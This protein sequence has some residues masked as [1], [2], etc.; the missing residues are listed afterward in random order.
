MVDLTPELKIAL[1]AAI[2][3][4]R[5]RRHEFATTE[6]LMLALLEDSVTARAV[7]RCGGNVRRLKD[8]L[9]HFLD[10]H[11]ET[12]PDSYPVDVMPT[13]GFQEAVRRAVLNAQT[14]E[15]DVV[16]GPHVV[17]A[18]FNLRDCHAVYLLQQEGI[19]KL[20]LMEY[21]SHGGLDDE[22]YDLDDDEDEDDDDD[23]SVDAE[24]RG[25]DDGEPQSPKKALEKYAVNLNEEAAQGRID[26]MVGRARELARTIHVLCRRRKNNP[27]F[28][29]EAGVG[30]T[31]IVEGLAL[32]IHD[33]T[34]PRP[35]QDAVVYAL[36]VGALVAGTRYRGDFE[37]RLKAVV[38]RLEKLPH[39]ILFVDEIHTLI[40][41]GAAS[42]GA[43]DASSILKPLLARGKLRCI[44][45]TTWKEYRGIFERDQALSRRFQRITVDEPSVE[46]TIE[47][48]RGLKPRYEEFHGITFADDA[49]E[50]AAR[51]SARFLNDRF[52]PD[53]AIDVI[54][55][56]AAEVKLAER[57]RVE[58]ADIDNTLAR[59]ANVP[60]KQVSRD[61][62]S[63]L[64]E[65]E[66]EL[67]AAIYGQDEAIAQLATAIKLSRSGLGE[68]D[69]PIG[70]FLF[71]GPTGVGKTEVCRQLARVLGLEL[72]RY[73]MSEYME[74]HTVSRLI[75][76]PP[77]YVGFDQGGQLTD[78]VTKNPHSVVL[79]DEIEKAHPDV[80]NLL[81]QVMDHGTLTDNNGKKT[82]FRNV[83]LVMTSN[84]GARD[85]Q[86]ARPGF[87]AAGA[88]RAGD[89]DEAYKRRF[90]PEFRNRLDARIKFA[91]LPPEI[92][93][94][95]AD[96]FVRQLQAQLADRKV[97][98]EVTDTAR[99]VLARIGY[100]PQNGARPMARIIREKIKRPLADDLLF[101]RL[102]DG[103]KLVVDAESKDA[104]VFVF[105]FPEAPAGEQVLTPAAESEPAA[106]SK[107]AAESKPAAPDATVNSGAPAPSPAP[108]D[109]D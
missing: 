35:L 54:D 68:P 8:A 27:V 42:G 86:R 97:E 80:F 53:K 90:S 21:V 33:K 72:L 91:P 3:T 75:G 60:P 69:K 26:P 19:N 20:D 76:A 55:E 12:L 46:E 13:L 81:L 71:S 51:A 66:G 41:A 47:I 6:H 25:E 105:R 92:M 83:I 63:R 95:V 16:A 73:D 44:G 94:S 100:D 45:A 103:G 99:Q 9:E 49:I 40:G 22:D 79:L 29:G 52:L 65:L 28:V 77:G 108:A 14:S 59:M 56:A 7:R 1:D 30:K 88:E 102:A 62:R 106:A 32:A 58:V 2:E 34:V 36:D 38:K 5:Y 18:M 67:K 84:I 64:A 78:A 48:L 50:E 43:L 24:E 23:E 96:K 98:I 70:S 104:D 11:V 89:D 17:V 15:R 107:P 61:D 87:F 10:E 93:V 37:E 101:G 31:A 85:L 74:R 109:E 39:A 57:P 4:A 82:D